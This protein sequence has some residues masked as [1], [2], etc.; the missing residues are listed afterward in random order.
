MYPIERTDFINAYIGAI[1][2]EMKNARISRPKRHNGTGSLDRF[3][4]AIARLLR[5]KPD[6][7]WV[8][9]GPPATA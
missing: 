1:S 3:S 8:A 2:D 4:N 6:K 5:A 7:G 9:Q